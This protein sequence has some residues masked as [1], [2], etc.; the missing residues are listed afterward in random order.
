MPH[1][2]EL[3]EILRPDSAKKIGLMELVPSPF[4]GASRTPFAL[5]SMPDP[6]G[7]RHGR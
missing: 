6:V 4:S 2:N 3:R 5:A 1:V 7:R